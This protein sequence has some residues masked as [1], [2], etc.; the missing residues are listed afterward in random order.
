MDPI[1]TAGPWITER[2]KE[3]VQ[4]AMD[5]W[6]GED[7]YYYCET[8]ES[9]F[10]EWHNR[11]YGLMT[12][13]CTSAIHLLLRAI[14]IEPGDEVI[15]PECTWIGSTAGISYLGGTPVFCDVDSETWC[16]DPGS[17]EGAVSEDTRAIIAV[18]LHGNMPEMTALQE[19]ADTRDIY[20]L[21]DSAQA[22]GS[23][24]EGQKAGSFGTASFFSF[25]RTKTLTTGEGGM[26]LLDDDELFERCKTLRNHGRREGGEMYVNYDIGYKYLP[27]NVQAAIGYAQFQRVDELIEK[28]REILQGYREGLEDVWGIQ[29]NTEPPGG[30]NGAW[31]TGLVFDQGYGLTKAEAIDRL[32]DHGVPVRP[33]FYPLSS[34]PAY[35]TDV[36]EFEQQNPV[37]YDISGRGIDLPGAFT[38]TDDQINHVCESVRNVLRNAN[39]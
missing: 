20:L 14:G 13:N 17:V 29:L 27:F 9:E 5:N 31:I 26:L 38:L 33:F 32:A 12:P 15:V 22:L 24:Y 39:S 21:E 6:Y 18:D 37:A 2:E 4:D 36:E 23:E 34:L 7:K 35:P 28:K 25:H 1:Y 11:T 30:R 8:F 3:A 10:A 19:I 16:L